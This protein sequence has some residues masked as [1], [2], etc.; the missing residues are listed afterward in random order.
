VTPRRWVSRVRMLAAPALVVVAVAAC[1][2]ARTSDAALDSLELLPQPPTTPTATDAEAPEPPSEAEVACETEGPTASYRPDPGPLPSPDE[3]PEGSAMREIQ[4]RGRLIV[5]VD[6]S[7][8]GFSYRS[9]ST[10]EI[11]GFEVDIAYEIAKR[12]FG[13][14]DRDLILQTKPV[15]TDEKTKVVE[16]NDV[17]LTV[18]AITMNCGRWADVAFSSEYYTAVQQFLVR[19]D[20]GIETAADLA[21]KKVCVT[22]GSSSIGL[23]E[24]H[25]PEAE[26]HE[27]SARTDCLLALQEGDVVAYFGHDSFLY[28]MRPQDLTVEVKDGII[29]ETETRSNYGIA[30]SHDRPELVRFVNAVLEELRVDGTWGDLHD[31]LETELGIPDADP[32]PANYREG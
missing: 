5:G 20:S 12:I 26:R 2:S 25:L 22:A 23:L 15:I 16:E 8:K 13:P 19:E 18:S 10:G 24:D 9:Q 1:A 7:T 17:D 21:G 3:M 6:E 31:Q 32:P 14:L 4:E 27:V 30:I 11:E 28:G 29:P